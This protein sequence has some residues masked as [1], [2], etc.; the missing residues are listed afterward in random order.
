[1]VWVNLY[2]STCLNH[3]RGY[4]RGNQP[5]TTMLRNPRPAVSSAATPDS[6]AL[7][8]PTGVPTTL[9]P[10]AGAFAGVQ[11]VLDLRPTEYTM[12]QEAA[13]LMGISPDVFCRDA[14]IGRAQQVLSGISAPSV[15]AGIPG[16]SRV[17]RDA[18][19]AALSAASAPRATPPAAVTPPASGGSPAATTAPAKAAATPA[20]T[21]AATTAT[22]A[23]PPA[24]ASTSPVRERAPASPGSAPGVKGSRDADMRKWVE[25]HIAKGDDAKVTPSR[26]ARGITPPTGLPTALAFLQREYP[27]FVS[28]T[29]VGQSG[30]APAT[31]GGTPAGDGDEEPRP[32]DERK[33]F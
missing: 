22:T 20:A 8:P 28:Q 14:I 27:R 6:R 17:G 4:G 33:P 31:P 21:P 16:A 26:L 18:R 1:M 32:G 11:G 15:P 12:I 30:G 23:T 9:L 13:R 24:A 3:F 5:K 19:G 10:V 29:S 25:D 2:Y 7:K